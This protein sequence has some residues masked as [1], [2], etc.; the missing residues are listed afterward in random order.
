MQTPLQCLERALHPW[1]AFGI[2]PLFAL[3]NAGVALGML[4]GLVVGKQ[5][6]VTLCAWLAVRSGLADLPEGVGWRRVYDADWLA[7]I[8]FTM[9]LFIGSLAFGEGVLLDAAKVGI[10]A[11]SLLAG[12]VGW[13]ILRFG[14]TPRPATA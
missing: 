1:V 11:A 2:V 10:L 12:V 9:S 14:V 7:G 13:G 5:A 8:G 6:G 4:L 3:A